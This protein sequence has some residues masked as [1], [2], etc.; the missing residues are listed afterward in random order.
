MSSS[1]TNLTAGGEERNLGPQHPWVGN[2]TNVP[3]HQ[4]TG[5]PWPAQSQAEHLPARK[6]SWGRLCRPEE[7]LSRGLGVRMEVAGESML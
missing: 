2:E 1:S 7:N 5:E 6:V 3:S 4:S